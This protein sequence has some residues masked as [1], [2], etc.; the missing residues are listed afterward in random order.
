MLSSLCR[1]TAFR[2]MTVWLFR[3][4]RRATNKRH[5]WFLVCGIPLS[6]Q[7]PIQLPPG[8][9]LPVRRCL[10]EPRAV[11]ISLACRGDPT[12]LHTAEDAQTGAPVNRENATTLARLADRYTRTHASPLTSLR[13]RSLRCR[14][15]STLTALQR[16]GFVRDKRRLCSPAGLLPVRAGL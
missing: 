8:T 14:M 9:A 11:D 10:A 12:R 16:L 15:G 2:S 13:W 7:A 5:P 6:Y 3:P 1:S 4:V